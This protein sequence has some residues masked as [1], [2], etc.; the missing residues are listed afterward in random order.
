MIRLCP[1]A[2]YPCDIFQIGQPR[3]GLEAPDEVRKSGAKIKHDWRARRLD[4]DVG[5]RHGAEEIGADDAVHGR[6]RVLQCLDE[7]DH[8]IVSVD[9][10]PLRVGFTVRTDKTIGHRE[11]WI[12]HRRREIALPFSELLHDAPSPILLRT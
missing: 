12:Q 3:S 4:H 7:A 2:L 11:R 9:G 8:D 1:C 5:S 10:E 6:E